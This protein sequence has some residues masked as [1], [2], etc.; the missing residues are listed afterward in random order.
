M[1]EI[2]KLLE[3]VLVAELM[4]LAQGLKNEQLAKGVR[5]TSD[6]I[7]EAIALFKMKRPDV[8]QRLRHNW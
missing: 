6:Y 8:L 1:E 7:D 2:K 3:D 4:N 5:S